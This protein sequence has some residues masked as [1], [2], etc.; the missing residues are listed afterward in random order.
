MY[1]IDRLHDPEG[2][3]EWRSWIGF[4]TLPDAVEYVRRQVED[5]DREMEDWNAHLWRIV[6]QG[7]EVPA[8]FR[9][10]VTCDLCG[11]R[12]YPDEAVRVGDGD[13]CPEDCASVRRREIEEE[14][15]AEEELAE[16]CLG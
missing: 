3:H 9:R 1:R 2:R 11:R 4:D 14:R 5:D 6:H 10:T 13:Y 15:E 16:A 8:E 7:R 12:N